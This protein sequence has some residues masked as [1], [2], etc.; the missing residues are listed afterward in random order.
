MVTQEPFGSL[1]RRYRRDAELT[2][3]VLAE[4]AGVSSRVIRK[5]ESGSQQRPRRDTVQ[6][7][8]EALAVPEDELPAFWAAASQG[9]FAVPETGAGR[10]AAEPTGQQLPT[11]GFAGSLP[12]GRM[13]GREAELA[14]ILRAVDA[15]VSGAGRLVLLA[16][17]PGVGKT[18]LVQEVTVAVCERGFVVAAGRCYES[19]QTVP[20][21]PFLDVVTALWALAPPEIRADAATRWPYL[22]VLLPEEIPVPPPLASPGQDEQQRVFRAVTGFLEAMTQLA[23]IVLLLDDLHWADVASLTL[24]RHV[25][26]HTRSC[27]LLLLGSYRD[28]EVGRQHPLSGVLGDLHRDGVVERVDVR[29][30]DQAGTAA[31]VAARIGVET[32]SQEFAAL[33]H[34]RTEGNPYFVHQVLQVLVERGDLFHTDGRWDRRAI[35]ELTVPE[36][37]RSAVGQRVARLSGEA[38]QLLGEASVLGQTFRFEDLAQLGTHAESL[39]EQALEEAVDVGLVREV[40]GDAYAFDHALSQQVCYDELTTRRR[41]RLHLAAGRA[42]EQLPDR[43]RAQRLAELA[44]HFVQG[45]DGEKALLYALQAGDAAAAVFANQDAEGQYR[46]AVRLA[47]EG[48]DRAQE[49]AALHKLGVVVGRIGRPDEACAILLASASTYEDCDDIA[50]ALRVLG[51]ATFGLE[52][53]SADTRQQLLSHLQRLVD[54]APPEPSATLVQAYSLLANLYFQEGDQEECLRLGEHAVAL[55]EQV[56][57]PL[58]RIYALH[59]LSWGLCLTGRLQDSWE[60]VGRAVA[61]AEDTADH[62]VLS[63]VLHTWGVLAHERGDWPAGKAALERSF[64]YMEEAGD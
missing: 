17:E 49:A 35:E 21:Y 2:Q 54:H 47:R 31:L 56:D 15:V 55:A 1:V 46:T 51:D 5:I 23:P 63:G 26:T 12:V 25:A 38:Q 34:S 3:E 22:G 32:V 20:Y 19:E 37:I 42:L 40:A 18:R 13:V 7:L 53:G 50:G 30:L 6:L 43:M 64:A 58:V 52:L 44:W 48:E 59:S 10:S 33:V 14:N 29:R 8:L 39:V 45:D 61:L 9:W 16:G 24:L 36:S 60:C 62:G 28:V 4:R 41:R 27:R 11:G 57:D